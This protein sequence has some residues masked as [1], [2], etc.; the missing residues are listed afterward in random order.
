[1]STNL[2]RLSLC[3]LCALC[4][5]LLLSSPALAARA[6]TVEENVIEGDLLGLDATPSAQ[7]RVGGQSRQV[8][9]S[10]LLA[11]ELR[12]GKPVPSLEAPAFILRN[13]DT[14]RGAIAGGSGSAIV[15]KSPLLGTSECPLQAIARIEFPVARPLQPLQAAEK[16]DR[17]LFRNGETLE[18][19]VESLDAAGMKFRSALLG[20][21][22][23]GSDRLASVVFAAQS[24]PAPATPQGVVAIVHA[25]DGTVLSGAIQGLKEGKLEVRASF[26]ASLALDLARVLRIE[27]RGG[28]LVYLSDLEP[29]QVKE[30]PFFDLTWHYRRDRSVDGNSLRLGEQAYPKGL[31]VHSRCEL[32]YALDGAYRR[33]LADVGIDE[34]V[35][36]RGNVDV[37]VLVDG[38]P[39]YERKGLTGRD[40]PLR[41]A[42]DVAGASRLTLVVDFGQEFDICDHADWANARLIR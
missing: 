13:G 8:P 6:I 18:G 35:G 21:L 30:T 12:P 2:R 31:G 17:L 33:F 24:G 29:V 37:T 15:V 26:G 32:A 5:A 42:I 22:E 11:L 27:F 40:E 9:C 39:R 28:R 10:D 34:E 7:L 25:D 41:V 36:E 4:G 16:L 38:K 20:Q 1:M 14:L 23:I 19:T 3:I